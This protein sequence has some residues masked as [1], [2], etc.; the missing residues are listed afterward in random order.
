MNLKHYRNNIIL[1][2]K[3]KTWLGHSWG[4]GWWPLG[5]WG[6]V[7]GHVG[8]SLE[9]IQWGRPDG[10]RSVDS[11]SWCWRNY[12]HPSLTLGML[13]KTVHSSPKDWALVDRWST[14]DDL[15]YSKQSLVQVLWKC[16][17]IQAKKIRIFFS[18][19]DSSTSE[20]VPSTLSPS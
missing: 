16:F 4:K 12:F 7:L 1:T 9:P 2:A 6:E 20:D 15:L 8:G 19:A 10:N 3:D 17:A 14:F 18:D 11:S 13:L 5:A